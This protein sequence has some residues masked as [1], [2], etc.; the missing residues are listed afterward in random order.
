MKTSDKA[1]K[2]VKDHRKGT[3]VILYNAWDAGSAKT[4]AAAGA[5]AI[6]TSSWAVAA[7]QGY[8]DGEAIPL[9][10][11]ERLISRI[12][13]S[14][15]LPVTVD[16]ESGYSDDDAVLSETISRLVDIGII[17]VNFED[18]LIGGDVLR[19]TDQQARRISTIRRSAEHKGVDLFI[20]ARTDVYFI[21]ERDHEKT[22]PEALQRAEAYAAAG[23]SGVFYPGL[24]NP[25]LISRICERV[26][27]P[28]NIMVMQGAPAKA[29][30]AALGV[31]RISYGNIPYVRAMQALGQDAATIL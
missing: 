11:V 23:A 21:P 20:N 7:A 25:E 4:I 15:D 3:P 9:D 30:L 12:V 1:G 6:A 16:I 18:R 10:F 31:A 29:E 26:A 17:G 24:I 14:V 13:E 5:Q 27:L 28:V 19:D 22:L 2:F 8:K